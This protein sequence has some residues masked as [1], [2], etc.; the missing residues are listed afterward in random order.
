MLH[1]FS[2]TETN[3]PLYARYTLRKQPSARIEALGRWSP[4]RRSSLFTRVT[5]QTCVRAG[6]RLHG[7]KASGTAPSGFDFRHTRKHSLGATSSAERA[8]G[9][10]SAVWAGT[11]FCVEEVLQFTVSALR[12]RTDEHKEKGRHIR[13]ATGASDASVIFACRQTTPA[14]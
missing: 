8:D 6:L 12:T 10:R 4:V 3:T 14:S 7:I 5:V 2:E 13:L 11:H 9:V 1:N